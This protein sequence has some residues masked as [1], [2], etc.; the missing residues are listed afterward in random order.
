MRLLEQRI[1][2]SLLLLLGFS[3]LLISLY[4]GQLEQILDL[5]KTALKASIIGL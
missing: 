1:I 2:A 3:F 4:S 5:V